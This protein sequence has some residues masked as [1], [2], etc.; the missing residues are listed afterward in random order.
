MIQPTK[1]TKSL[2]TNSIF[3]VIYNTLNIVFPLLTSMY[4]ARV[5]KTADIGEIGYSQNIAQYFVILS[6]LGIPTYGMR[7]IA[8][9]RDSQTETNTIFS[10]LFTL[11]FISTSIFLFIYLIC[12]I[13][14]KEFRNNI[15]IFLISGLS[16]VLN[17]MNINWLYEGLE[18]F[19]YISLRNILFK[20]LS[21]LLLVILVRSE[22]DYLWYAAV[23]V[24]GT[25]GNYFLNVI[26]SKKFVSLKIKN[27]DL[28]RHLKSISYLVVVNL[29]IEIYSLVDI[30]MLGTMSEK[31]NVAFYSYA[32]R[33]QKILLHIVNSFTM[34]IVPRL[35]YYY[36]NH[37]YQ[38]Y[39][40]LISQTLKIIILL[41]FPMIIG[42]IFTGNELITIMYGEKYLQSAK[43]LNILSFLLLISPI[44]YLLGSRVLLISEQETKMIICVAI[45]AIVNVIC[46]FFF[47][48]KYSEI[49]AAFASLTSEIVVMTIYV[50]LGRKEYSLLIQ[51]KDYFKIFF[52]LIAMILYLYTIKKLIVNKI[53]CVITQIIGAVI[54]YFG[55]LYLLNEPMTRK[56]G[57]RI[58][59]TNKKTFIN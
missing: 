33:I 25:A 17:Y 9:V 4:V 58:I 55:I 2:T 35:S 15:T 47:I 39:N 11:N 49:G 8:K 29:A 56:Y 38:E 52:S 44:G 22:A 36:K 1:K 24:F 16:I 43:V 23:T 53:I 26:Y 28:K 19:R 6:F 20:L 12:I 46:N 51:I 45:G 34:V 10:E 48:Q 31:S 59:R 40:K 54:V 32:L 14:I 37:L 3:Y 13:L 5:L 57:S 7:E 41:S 50:Y 42:I 30:T 27:L 18:E 21:F